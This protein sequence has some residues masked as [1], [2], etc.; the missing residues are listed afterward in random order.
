MGFYSAPTSL[1]SVQ[2]I[3]TNSTQSANFTATAN[4]NYFVSASG[5]AITVTL[6]TST[7]SQSLLVKKTDTSANTVTISGTINGVGSAT[8]AIKYQNQ[9]KQLYADGSG[10]WNVIGGDADWSSASTT[11]VLP[12]TG[13]ASITVGTTAPSSPAVGDLWVDTN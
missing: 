13:T 5:G 6:P 3:R 9:S 2:A 7:T 12:A 4:T 1:T 10:G 11:G 8:L